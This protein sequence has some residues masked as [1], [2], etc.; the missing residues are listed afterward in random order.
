[1]DIMSRRH[2]IPPGALFFAQLCHGLSWLLLAFIAITLGANAPTGPAI[3]WIHLVALGWFTMA[4]LG[5]LI[6]VIPAFTDAEWLHRRLVRTVLVPLAIG[7]VTFAAG[8]FT[9][10]LV[11]FIGALI[12]TLS[13]ITYYAV[14]VSTLRRAKDAGATEAAIGRALTIN[15]SFLLAAALL[16]LAMAVALNDAHLSALLVR[17]PAIHANVAL[18]GWLTMLVYGVSA[19]TMRPICGARSRFP[20]IHILT[21]TSVLAGPLLVA[22]GVG[23]ATPW[24]TWA[25]AIVIGSGTIGYAF[26]MADIV[27]RATTPHR[28][29]QAFV[30]ASIVWLVAASALGLAMLLGAPCAPAFVFVLLVGWIG[31]MI[32]AHMLHIGVRL[33]ATVVRGEDD[34][35]RP[36]VLLDARLSWI[37]FAGMQLAVALG[38]AGLLADAPAVTA[39]GACIGFVAWC[40]MIV[41]AATA[42]RCARTLPIVLG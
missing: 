37:A 35:T 18:Y 8:W 25:G 15:L 39:T 11:T 27:R 3:A 28:P 30:V 9:T 7:V 2:W 36:G 33:I 29:P 12:L 4:A 14:A 42:V 38:A 41:N 13:V 34:E 21:G 10:T 1:M 24:L 26:D 32:N 5:V 23:S 40:S 17:T 16:G 20:R 19:R 6:H 31:Q 22:A